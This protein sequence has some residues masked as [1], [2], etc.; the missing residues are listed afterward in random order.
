[1]EWIYSIT[2]LLRQCPWPKGW[3]LRQRPSQESKGTGFN[4]SINFRHSLLYCLT[5]FIS[6]RKVDLSPVLSKRAL[7]PSSQPLLCY[8]FRFYIFFHSPRCIFY[9]D[10]SVF[11][12][13]S[14]TNLNVWID[15]TSIVLDFYFCWSRS[16]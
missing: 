8:K 14:W 11:P 15:S 13:C 10:S 16:I 1:M 3:G 4:Y 6:C 9:F 7:D 2:Y 12:A 5:C